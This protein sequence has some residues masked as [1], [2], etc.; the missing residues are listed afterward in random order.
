MGEW[1]Q[2][3]GERL[4]PT[5]VSLERPLSSSLPPGAFLVFPLRHLSASLALAELPLREVW[6]PCAR[7]PGSWVLRAS[8][9]PPWASSFRVV[10]G[11]F[12]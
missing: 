11:G 6:A 12:L 8:P 5:R 3:E 7:P 2:Q 9:P 10:S 4:L 1:K